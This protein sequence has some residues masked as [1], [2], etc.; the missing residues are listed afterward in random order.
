MTDKQNE[1]VEQEEHNL[2][3]DEQF[4]KE[5]SSNTEVIKFIQSKFKR[6]SRMGAHNI[7]TKLLEKNI[8]ISAKNITKKEKSFIRY[9]ISKF[10]DG[11]L[12]IETIEDLR[13][14]LNGFL[15]SIDKDIVVF[16]DKEEHKHLDVGK[17]EGEE[18]YILDNK[19]LYTKVRKLTCDEGG[20]N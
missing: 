1:P 15:L 2:V 18:C 5:Y 4:V 20:I 14:S 17:I 19:T 10:K 13:Y 11:Q 16:G 9:N 3:I 12:T 7:I 8:H 6:L